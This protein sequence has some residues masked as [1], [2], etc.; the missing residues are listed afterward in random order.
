MTLEEKVSMLA[1]A[2]QWFS[3]AVPRLG[4]PAFKMSDGPHGARGAGEN[5]GPTSAAFP[6]GTAMAATWN[7]ELIE[8]VGKAL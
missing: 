2:D 6:I 7:T 8:Q 4:I 5:S 1:G 3:T